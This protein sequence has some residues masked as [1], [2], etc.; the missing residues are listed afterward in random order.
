MFGDLWISEALEARINSFYFTKILQKI[1]EKYGNFLQTCFSIS[2]LFGNPKCQRFPRRRAPKNDEDPSKN[3]LKSLDMYFISI[4]K[5][6][7][8]IG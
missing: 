2:Q 8:E 3:F 1:Q 6:E 7:M 5:H 4:K